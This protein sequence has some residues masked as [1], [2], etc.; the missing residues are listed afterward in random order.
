M[1]SDRASVALAQAF[2]TAQRYS[3]TILILRHFEA[4]RDS[5]SPEISPNDQRG[6]TSE[7]AS[8]IRKFTE[9]VGEHDDSNSLMKSNGEFVEKNVE[10]TSGHQVLLI[11]A[12]DSSEGLPS[13]IRRYFSHETKMRPLTEE[14]RAE[15]LLHSLENIYGLHSNTDLEDAGA[16]LFPS[17]NVEVD[18]VEP[19]GADSSLSSKVTEDNNESEVSALKSRKEDL[20]NA[21]ERSKKRNASALGTQRFQT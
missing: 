12:A 3:P 21:L 11:A 19:E 20:V 13:T 17:S 5:H 4:F 10:K 8:V 15:M 14:Q 9:S 18:K 16:N 6:N 2:K 1:G 7:V